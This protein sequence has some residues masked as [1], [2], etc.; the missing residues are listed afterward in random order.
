MA[1]S[2]IRGYSPQIPIFNHDAKQDNDELRK[3]CETDQSMR[4]KR[5]APEEERQNIFDAE[6]KHREKIK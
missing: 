1:K 6:R 2:I 5:P 4:Q 3:L